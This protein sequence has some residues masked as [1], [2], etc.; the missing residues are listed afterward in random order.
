MVDYILI[1]YTTV[2]VCMDLSRQRI[3][4]RW[5]LLG[6]I[7][8]FSYQVYYYQLSGA[9]YFLIGCLLPI[10]V[11]YLLFWFRM[12]GAGD[13][14]LL[15]VLGGFIGPAAVFKCIGLSLLFGAILSLAILILCGNFLPRLRYF[16][17]YFK[18]FFKTKK[19]VPYMIRGNRMEHIHFS[20]PVFM[21]VLLY[22]GGVY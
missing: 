14:K 13:I 2:A 3:D 19:A 5:I 11:L 20:I 18:H 1:V 15:S 6:W 21:A 7:G 12:L 22:V 9:G 10:V 16:T 17:D 4:N 8:G